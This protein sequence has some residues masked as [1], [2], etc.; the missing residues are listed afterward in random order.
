MDVELSRLT[1][2]VGEAESR[3]RAFSNLKNIDQMRVDIAAIMK[4]IKKQE[5]TL[6]EYI[7]LSELEP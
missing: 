5:G 1:D 7:T 6:P 4:W 3:E 2:I